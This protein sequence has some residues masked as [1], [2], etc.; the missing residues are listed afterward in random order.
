MLLLDQPALRT[1]LD[2]QDFARL[3]RQAA[4]AGSMAIVMDKDLAWASKCCTRVI[5][6]EDGRVANR[7]A[8][9]RAEESENTAIERFTPFKAPA[10]KE[11]RI[12]L[13]DPGE[14]L[15][16]TSRDG[17]TYLRTGHEEVVTNLTL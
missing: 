9:S 14:I 5:E 6:V 15:Y 13:Y 8:F 7:Y 17:K 16:A 10:R 4:E 1:D 3:I 11:D 2:T 12:L